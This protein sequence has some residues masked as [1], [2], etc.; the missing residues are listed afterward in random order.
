[1][2]RLNKNQ[3]YQTLT[4]PVSARLMRM[5]FTGANQSHTELHLNPPVTSVINYANGYP[6]THTKFQAFYVYCI[7]NAQIFML[8]S[9]NLLFITLL[10]NSTSLCCHC[11]CSIQKSIDEFKLKCSSLVFRVHVVLNSNPQLL[12]PFSVSSF[13]FTVGS[14]CF[15]FTTIIQG[16]VTH[17]QNNPT[18]EKNR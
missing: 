1:M 13:L 3:T 2:C 16:D 14:L 4:L 8:T 18:I 11:K 7:A 10:T 15:S 5:Q 6:H 9:Y 12:I 17:L